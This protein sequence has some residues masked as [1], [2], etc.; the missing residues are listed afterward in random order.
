MWVTQISCCDYIYAYP[1][2]L[3]CSYDAQNQSISRVEIDAPGQGYVDGHFN[4]TSNEGANFESYFTVNEAGAIVDISIKAHGRAFTA[5]PSEYDIYYPGTN[6][7][8]T[9]S[10]TGLSVAAVGSGYVDGDI[11]LLTSPDAGFLASV[12][13]NATSGAIVSVEILSHGVNI[14]EPAPVVTI[15]FPG[16]STPQESSVT[17]V[18]LADERMTSGCSVGEALTALGGGHI[19]EMVTTA[20]SAMSFHGQAISSPSSS[21]ATTGLRFSAPDRKVDRPSEVCGKSPP[22]GTWMT[23]APSASGHV[24]SPCE[25]SSHS[26]IFRKLLSESE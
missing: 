9:N 10:I 8:Q 23:P 24:S 5:D 4:I 6:V 17:E 20:I 22:P 16:S 3:I 13:A 15:C 14:T 25:S 19:S 7:K 21:F 26:H 12:A 2:R 1:V 11:R 18:K